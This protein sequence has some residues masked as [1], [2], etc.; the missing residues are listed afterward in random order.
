MDARRSIIKSIWL[1][2]ITMMLLTIIAGVVFVFV[3]TQQCADFMYDIGCNNIASILYF[4]AYEDKGDI[5]DCY[6][7]LN[8]KITLGEYEKIVEY[9]EALIEDEK[10][11]EFIS[12]HIQN[13]EKL[14]ISVLEKSAILNDRNYLMNSYVKALNATEQ[15]DKAKLVAIEEFAN[16]D[17]FD[18]KNQ[19]VYALG[20]FV[21]NE[22]W[23]VF[24]VQYDGF[25]NTLV[26]EMQSYFDYLVELF[27]LYK[28]VEGNTD[29]AYLVALGN[30]LIDVGQ[31][32]N[33][34]YTV[35]DAENEVISTNVSKMLIVNNVIKGII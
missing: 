4:K 9:Y 16:K 27:D 13:R 7:A 22:K 28:A 21:D 32:I 11:D 8:I 20:I 24:S 19:G 29:K 25:E 2:L 35:T 10:F 17:N 12:S 34:V 31:D 3:F 33:A 18:F 23:D 1:T 14:D 6:R 15:F 30:R 26:V 5:D